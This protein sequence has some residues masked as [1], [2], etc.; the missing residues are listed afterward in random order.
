MKS[1][2]IKYET[3]GGYHDIMVVYSHDI[4]TAIEEFEDTE[5]TINGIKVKYSRHAIESI[6]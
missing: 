4:V 2:E 6:T 3:E 5:I 1:W